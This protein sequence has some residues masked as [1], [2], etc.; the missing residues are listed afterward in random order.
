[1]E[2]QQPIF[3][4][5]ADLLAEHFDIDR[6]RLTPETTFADLEF[7]SL[8]LMEMLVVA[9][10]DLGMVLGDNGTEL[11]ATSTLAE[12]TALMERLGAATAQ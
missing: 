12:A 10:S 1:M 8:A 3:D 9:E 6:A 7:D 2:Q 5:L 11:D 4:T